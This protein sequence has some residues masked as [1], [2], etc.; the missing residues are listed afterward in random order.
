MTE[1]DCRS[2]QDGKTQCNQASHQCIKPNGG[3]STKCNHNNIAEDDENCDGT[4]LRNKQCKDVGSFAAG[5]LHCN[6]ECNYETAG[7]YE[8]VTDSNCTN[9]GSK[10]HCNTLSHRCSEPEKT[11]AHFE[12]L[13]DYT[14]GMD[15]F[16]GNVFYQSNVNE[17]HTVYGL[18]YINECTTNHQWCPKVVGASV[19]YSNDTNY[20]DDFSQWKRID[21]T[22]N[23]QFNFSHP[24]ENNNEY[25]ATLNFSS[26]G[27]YRYVYSFDLK[28]N[29]DDPNEMPQT[30]FCYSGWAGTPSDAVVGHATIVN[31][32]SCTSADNYCHSEDRNGSYCSN[33]NW[34]T[35][36]CKEGTQCTRD[37]TGYL[38][39]VNNTEINC[40]DY[41]QHC[42]TND[43][44]GT[45][46]ENGNWKT[47]VCPKGTRCDVSQGTSIYCKADE[48]ECKEGYYGEHC[49]PCTCK[50]GVCDYGKTGTGKCVKCHD[51]FTGENCNQCISGYQCCSY[52]SNGNC[53]NCKPDGEHCCP[54][55][56][57][58]PY[59]DTC[60]EGY[61]RC[62]SLD[63]L[64]F[65]N[66]SG[67][68]PNDDD[69]QA[70]DCKKTEEECCYKTK[71]TSIPLTGEKCDQ[72]PP[73]YYGP[74]CIECTCPYYDT[75]ICD[76]GREGNGQ[77]SACREGY[78]GDNCSECSEGYWGY[79]Q[80]IFGTICKKCT[81][82]HGECNDGTYGDGYCK[83]EPRFVYEDCN[84]CAPFLYG[85]DCN[86]LV[87]CKYS[88]PTQ[89]T[90]S[91]Y[92]VYGPMSNDGITGDG[93]CRGGCLVPNIIG[94]N[95]D[96]CAEGWSSGEQ[97]CDTYNYGSVTDQDGNTYKTVKIDHQT[98]MAENYRRAIGTYHHVNN[99]AAND[100]KLGLL[101]N[102]ATAAS[103]NFCPVGWHLP[104]WDDFNHLKEYADHIME[105]N[106]PAPPLSA[107]KY[108]ETYKYSGI[109]AL[110]I[111]GNEAI[112][113][114]YKPLNYQYTLKGN[115]LAFGA[116]ATGFYDGDHDSFENYFR[117]TDF[118]TCYWSSTYLQGPKP[119]VLCLKTKNDSINNIDDYSDYTSIPYSSQPNDGLPVRCIKD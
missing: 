44:N 2:R 85:N 90:R 73:N 69:S 7:C 26:S 74:Y 68:D 3:I 59:C 23:T 76:D 113:E 8:C 70:L 60:A 119:D 51:G 80:G 34:K 88:K 13:S 56:F 20:F 77:C 30:V 39:C 93:T 12:W 75:G 72:C 87:T 89:S 96:Q 83:C 42:N 117:F 18:I 43:K 98:W 11:Q 67:Y 71:G 64:L 62:F 107:T 82:V 106:L 9:K 25:M 118:D 58:G 24:N 86:K 111:V 78:T 54:E 33:G 36:T 10:T 15:A 110:G 14:C 19:H 95:C 109:Q 100:A 91:N 21:A 103:P 84:E 65:G 49:D 92:V 104:T 28:N 29:P 4:D 5:I 63:Q 27:R 6:N 53:T 102:W 22:K 57:D 50:N 55:G 105:I 41:E 32:N 16:E 112:Y 79:Y 38:S 108:E 40:T 116:M 115:P 37:E 97:L 31:P 114:L 1:S 47:M 48:Q 94:Q 66:S 99:N 46:C 81:C 17:N 61:I 52:D 45:Y 101:Y 35:L